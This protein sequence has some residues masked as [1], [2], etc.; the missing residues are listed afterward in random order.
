MLI[1]IS[2]FDIQW[3]E[4]IIRSGLRL[5]HYNP[6][7]VQG[8]IT[9]SGGMDL[10]FPYPLP[11]TYN[12]DITANT[13][14]GII[15]PVEVMVPSGTDLFVPE[16]VFQTHA[17]SVA[18]ML[19]NQKEL[20][21]RLDYLVRRIHIRLDD[22]EDQVLILMSQIPSTEVAGCSTQRDTHPVHVPPAQEE[23]LLLLTESRMHNHE[24]VVATAQKE[25]HTELLQVVSQL[26]SRVDDLQAQVLVV[27]QSPRTEAAGVV[28]G[29]VMPAVATNPDVQLLLLSDRLAR[30]EEGINTQR[31]VQNL[32]S[33]T[34]LRDPQKQPQSVHSLKDYISLYVD[35]TKVT[36]DLQSTQKNILNDIKTLDIL[37]KTIL[38]MLPLITNNNN[39]PEGINSTII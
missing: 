4:S 16:D 5:H 15:L 14:P 27:P 17:S 8:D 19:Q 13:N 6:S 9:A 33:T 1:T 35:E 11:G 23:E 37:Y 21:E 18:N 31:D 30:L 10:T 34:I 2:P 36:E 28:D 12:I 32:H 24:H 3:K 7:T 20:Q 38:K 26:A 29:V 22:V 25:S 39:Q